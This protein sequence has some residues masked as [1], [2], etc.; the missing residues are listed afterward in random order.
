MSGL[1]SIGNTST[2]S[3]TSP[4]PLNSAS[5][6]EIVGS[7]PLARYQYEGDA[8]AE[9][10][11]LIGDD[12]HRD[13]LAALP[14][15]R[16]FAHLLA[17]DHAMAEDL[18]Q[19]TIVRALTYRHQFQPGTNL[20]GW[21]TIILRN[22][23]FNEIR[24]RSRKAE[25]HV[26]LEWGVGSTSGGQE[27]NLEVRDF[28]RAFASL[29]AAQREALLLVGASG[30]SYEEAAQITNCAVGT[31]KSRVSRARLQLQQLLD[32]AG[33]GRRTKLAS[34]ANDAS[35]TDESPTL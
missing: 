27:E 34:K 5:I 11:R 2:K 3:T 10:G 16:A 15:L 12:M 30:V 22:R 25:L 33:T 7:K 29:P 9:D 24:R 23:Y 8:V 13:I 35:E 26:E 32:G 31:I 17:R 1:Q 14:H 28:K 20:R 18:V 21:L 4:F 19:D 6:A